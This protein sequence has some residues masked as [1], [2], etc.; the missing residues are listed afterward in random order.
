MKKFIQ[1]PTTSTI[2]SDREK[3]NVIDM[4]TAS[5]NAV[6][7]VLIRPKR[8]SEYIM[9]R[10]LNGK[11]SCIPKVKVS[12]LVIVKP[13]SARMFGNQPPRPSAAPK[14]TKKQIIAAMMR[15]R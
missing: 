9:K 15:L 11:E 8:S 1:N 2:V 4:T 12:D 13:R 14:N 6:T 3:K 10:L 7:E 5:T